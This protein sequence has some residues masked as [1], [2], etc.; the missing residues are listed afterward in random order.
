M[1][2]DNGAE[3]VRYLDV[4]P[5]LPINTPVGH[6]HIID[7]ECLDHDF[8]NFQPITI[9]DLVVTVL[10]K[11]TPGTLTAFLDLERPRFLYI[12][13]RS[14]DFCIKRIGRVVTVR[15]LP[16]DRPS[17]LIGSFRWDS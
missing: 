12:Q 10:F 14:L 4:Y 17:G 8:Y 1:D 3:P 16:C 9:A 7:L 6:P 15:V 5:K 11:F 2:D 13:A